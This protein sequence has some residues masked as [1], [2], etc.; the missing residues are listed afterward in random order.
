MFDDVFAFVKKQKK[1][2]KMI[3][4]RDFLILASGRRTQLRVQVVGYESIFLK[5]L[6]ASSIEIGLINSVMS[7]VSIL[8][9]VPSGWLTDRVKNI[10]KM[11]V[12]SS[13]LG[14]INYLAMA[15]TS[16]WPIY[17]VVNFW[18]TITDRL[19]MPAKTI[20]DIDSLSNIDRVRGLSVH[21]TITAVG[22]IGGPIFA[23]YILTSF[24]GLNNVDSFRYLFLFQFVIN[25]VIFLVMWRKLDDVLFDRDDGGT[26]VL[27]S[28][29]SIFQGSSALKLFFVKDVIQSFF[30]LMVRPFLGIYQVDVK[31]VTAFI[32]GYMGAG[33]MLVDVFLSLPMGGVI[34]RF[35]RRKIAYIGHLI[36]LV[37]RCILFLTPSSHPEFLI[38]YS[39]LGSVEGCMYLGWDAFTHE[40]VPQAVRGKYL[41]MRAVIVGII[42]VIAPLLGGIIWSINPNYLWW[43]NAIQ[44]ALVAFPLM[45]VLMEKYSS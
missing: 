45:V 6:G 18:R 38:L 30:G 17:T 43:I 41:G 10:K 26:G 22:G 25:A 9:S 31:L 44:W 5:R 14:I 39:I 35:G 8:F 42:G 24:G 21:R 15:L 7:L 23:A 28:F 36:G 1:N 13:G 11:Y 33:E 2:F 32:I 37:A 40:V 29:F 12:L 20:L 3:I 34:S 27:K 16:S 19:N 4:V